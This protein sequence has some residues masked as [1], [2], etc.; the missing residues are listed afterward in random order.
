MRPGRIVAGDNGSGRRICIKTDLRCR[1]EIVFGDDTRK[2]LGQIR[3]NFGGMVMIGGGFARFGHADMIVAGI[4]I[5]GRAAVRIGAAIHFETVER[6]CTWN[7]VG[8]IAQFSSQFT[9]DP[10]CT[11]PQLH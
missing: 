11:G 1:L 2:A 7:S 6:V 9:P 4:Q 5:A 3:K 10:N 8:C